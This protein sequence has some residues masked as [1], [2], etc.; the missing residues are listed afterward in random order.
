MTLTARILAELENG[1]ATSTKIAEAISAPNRHS[2]VAILGQYADKGEIKVIGRVPRATVGSAE[3]IYA[4]LSH[5]SP[6][7]ERLR[8]RKKKAPVAR[9]E[10]IADGAYAI[11]TSRIF[12]NFVFPGKGSRRGL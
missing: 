5:P 6:A 7:I 2:V 10:P 3:N 4:V 11:A 1:P 8:V 9:S 12:P